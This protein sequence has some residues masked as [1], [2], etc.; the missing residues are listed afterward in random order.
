MNYI[1]NKFNVDSINI[2]NDVITLLVYIC[3]FLFK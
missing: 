2:I 3:L 1:Y